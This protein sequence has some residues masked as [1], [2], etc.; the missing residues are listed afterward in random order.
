[1]L[2]VIASMIGSGIFITTGDILGMTQNAGLVLLLW[3]V[4][5]IVA[6]C[7]ATS[8]SQLSSMMPE[9]GGE[10]IYLRN[11]FGFLPAYLTG[12]VSLLVGFSASISLNALIVCEY[13][14]EIYSH[15]VGGT[16]NFHAIYITEEFSKLVAVLLIV[17][18]GSI[19]IIGVKFGSRTQNALTFVKLL[20]IVSF[21][22]GGCL[23]A[24]WSYVP[25]ITGSY[26]ILSETPSIPVTGVSLLAIMYSYSGWNATSY[27]AGEVKN[28]SKNVP[29]A[30]FLGTLI[31]VLLYLGLNVIF[32]LSVPGEK[33]VYKNAI[34]A[35]VAQNLFGQKISTLFSISIVVIL[36][37]SISVQ[38]M[39]GPRVYYAMARDNMIFKKLAYV[40]PRVKT[41]I[42]GIM[43]QMAIAAIYVIWGKPLTLLIY[44]GFS[45]NIFPLLS[46][47]G[48]VYMMLKN[49]HQFR[50]TRLICIFLTSS[51]FIMFSLF[52]LVSALI[53]WTRT[54]LISLGVLMA[55]VPIFYIWHNLNKQ[56]IREKRHGSNEPDSR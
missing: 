43:L 45:L 10:Y 1:M 19:H 49:T 8:Y 35:I 36:L 26:S 54:S 30:L 46:I 23:C 7:G 48:L 6:L 39:I 31:V 13:C 4:G 27:I 37:S 11:I 34:G 44:L 42:F 53:S 5:G 41:P 17:V 12:W 16:P 14:R 20:I 22:I 50:T 29:R 25:R 40:H 38:L 52:M 3:I 15:L 33:I 2:V 55:G 32:L 51:V 24:D 47:I 28:P 21:I 9:V 56:K 18:L